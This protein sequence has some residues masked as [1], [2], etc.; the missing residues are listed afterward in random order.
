[1]ASRLYGPEWVQDT[2]AR[3]ADEIAANRAPGDG[4][5]ILGLRTRGAVLA[6][7]LRTL[8]AAR[9]VDAPIGYLDA[10]LYRD[11]LHTGA[12][13][14][15]VQPTDI[16]FDLTGRAVILVDDVLSTG[17]T[18]RAAMGALFDYGRPG[19]VRLCVMVDRGCR[20]LPIWADFYGTRLEVPKGGGFVRVRLAG[21]DPQGDA[22]Y[23]VA[24]GDSEP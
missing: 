1:M 3:I 24:P 9:G 22:V 18:I 2:L 20:E 19:S 10:T 7:R 15:P 16:P 5:A 11:D 12:G 13:L 21:L 6:D 4:K 8:L 23:L 17:R 14:K